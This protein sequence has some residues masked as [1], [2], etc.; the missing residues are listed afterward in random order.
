MSTIREAFAPTSENVDQLNRLL[1][2]LS[3]IIL[4]DTRGFD[5]VWDITNRVCERWEHGNVLPRAAHAY[6]HAARVA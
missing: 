4:P 2:N 5:R 1:R 3:G 6:P